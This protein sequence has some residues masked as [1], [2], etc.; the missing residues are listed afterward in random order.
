MWIIDRYVLR[1]FIQVF[2]VCWISLTGLFTVFHAFSN[3]DEFIRYCETHDEPLLEVM[4]NF[5]AYRT[6]AFFDQISPILAMISAMFTVTWL[7][8]HNELTALMAAGFSRR[9]IVRPVI[10]AAIVVAGLALITREAIIPQ[11]RA[12]LVR[13]PRDLGGENPQPL[14]KQ[15]D[16]DTGV[17]IGGQHTFASNQR[18]H[19]PTFLL[20]RTIDD[21][22]RA[23]TALDCYFKPANEQ[24]PDGYLFE[25]VTSPLPLLAAPSL[26]LGERV[27]VFTPHD[28]SA[29]LKPNEC[30]IASS[31]AFIQL[32]GG[33]M[34]Q[35][36]S[37]TAELIDSMHHSNMFFAANTRVTIHSRFVQPALDIT[38]LFLGLP[39][40]MSRETRNLFMAIGVCV[41]LVTAFMVVTLGSQYVGAA[42]LVA[43]ATGAWLPLM[44]FVPLAVFLYDRVEAG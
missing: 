14:K 17:L 21:E 5:Y 24:H 37:S 27:I 15:Y 32:A 3:L 23:I 19:N 13:D 22:S 16:D 25:S 35:K 42:G 1:Q 38:L 39:L 11:C 20:P 7:Q 40:V 9:R 18:I 44:I 4:G 6:I 41:L 43:P 36:F 8:R 26:K 28:C 30:F 31:V 2:L 34:W 12:E 10:M 33:N 29:W